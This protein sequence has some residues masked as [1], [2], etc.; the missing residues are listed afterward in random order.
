MDG[1]TA[2]AVYLLYGEQ[3]NGRGI[4]TAPSM[5]V[6]RR[7]GH[8]FRAGQNVRQFGWTVKQDRQVLGTDP[9]F[10]ISVIQVYQ[11][12]LLAV[13]IAVQALNEFS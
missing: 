1:I 13:T 5:I 3:P 12:H 9:I 10:T 11:G 7:G 2:L 4:S 8:V 6:V